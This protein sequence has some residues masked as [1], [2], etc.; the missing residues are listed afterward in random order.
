MGPLPKRRLSQVRDLDKVE[1]SVGD[2]HDDLAAHDLPPEMGISIV[3]SA[4][5][6]TGLTG[7]VVT[8]LADR[9]VR[10]LA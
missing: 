4:P 1:P 7:A 5:L 2:R 10:G 9:L 3:P 8:I 6:R